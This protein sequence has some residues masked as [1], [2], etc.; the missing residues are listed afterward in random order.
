MYKFLSIPR[1]MEELFE[2]ARKEGEIDL[3]FSLTMQDTT[4]QETVDGQKY[5]VNMYLSY[6]DGSKR[7]RVFDT[8]SELFTLTGLI[9]EQGEAYKNFEESLIKERNKIRQTVLDNGF[10][11]QDPTKYKKD[12]LSVGC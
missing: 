3:Q 6:V 8:M 9:P 4:Q 1:N 2:K 12:P 7:I 11:F 10:G 5:E